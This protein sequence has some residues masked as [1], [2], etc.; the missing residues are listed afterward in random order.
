MSKEFID[1]HIVN[2]ALVRQFIEDGRSRA[3]CGGRNWVVKYVELLEREDWLD[4]YEK[5]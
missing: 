5:K 3:S 2:R 4:A 1:L